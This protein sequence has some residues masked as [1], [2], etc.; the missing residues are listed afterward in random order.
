MDKKITDNANAEQVE[1]WNGDAGQGW[2]DRDQQMAKTLGPIG[3]EAITAAKVQPGEAVLDIG[4]GCAGTSFALL[5]RV[6]PTGR[7][8]GVDISG[9]MLGAA[10][11]KA[12]E[13]PADQQSAISFEH[14]DASTYPFEAASFDL[15]FSRFGV[16]FFADPVAAFTNIRKALKPGGRIAFICWAPVPDN[17][18]ITVPMGAALKHLPRPEA[19]PPNA[20]GPFGLSN[21]EFVKQM[22]T[23]AGYSSITITS[24]RPTMRFGH[25][26]DR[27]RV[28]DFFIDAGP[29]S[30]LLTEASPE[31][32]GVVRQ[33]ITEAIMPHYDGDTVNL[34]ASCWIVT[35]S[36]S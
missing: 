25:G 16:M 10:A 13:L 28:A 9:P 29:V 19:T 12:Q 35:A 3:E 30:R 24:T 21:T 36:H 26:L 4:C 22:L 2:V 18:W 1:Y 33:A 23:E 20:P 32:V 27:D 11:A 6:G 8:L 31:Q 34:N 5:D 15:V 17:E 7:V 14:A